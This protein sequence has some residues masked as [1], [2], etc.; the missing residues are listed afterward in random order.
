[1][2]EYLPRGGELRL[3]RLMPSDCSAQAQGGR[4]FRRV[5]VAEL[6]AMMTP[7]QQRSLVF[8]VELASNA[9]E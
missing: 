2:V 8:R 6:V 5:F 4:V 1:M 3:S 7:R 9:T